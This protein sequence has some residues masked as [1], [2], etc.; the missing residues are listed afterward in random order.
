MGNY[1][2]VGLGITPALAKRLY[3]VYLFLVA[4]VDEALLEGLTSCSIS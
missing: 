2:Q 4:L 1:P 3:M